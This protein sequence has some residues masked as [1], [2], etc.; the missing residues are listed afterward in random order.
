LFLGVLA[1]AGQALANPAANAPD[2]PATTES[3]DDGDGATRSVP[4]YAE[5]FYNYELASSTIARERL[6]G[7][8]DPTGGIPLRRD[9]EFTS[10]KHTITPRIQVG[11]FKD[12]F[13]YAALP[14][15]I[16]QA[17]E[18][19]LVEGVSRTSS[20]TVQ[21]GLLPPEG[22]DARD[23]GTMTPGDLMFRSPKR[24][25]IDQIH[26]GLGVAPMNQ[27]SDPTK[28]TWKLGA[29]VRLA[30]GEIMK[31]DPTQPNANKG[32]SQG[33]QELK[34]WTSFTRKLGWAAPWVEAFWMTPLTAKSGSLFDDPGFGAT[35]VNKAMQAGLSFGLEV[36]AVDNAV[37]N[38]RI[39]LDLGTRVVGHFEGREYTEMWE[40][41]AGAGDSRGMGPLI[42]DADPTRMGVQALSHPGVSNIENY[43]ETAGRFGLRAQIGPHVKFGLLA[44]V[45]WKT[46]HAISFADAGVDYPTCGTAG[47]PC[48]DDQ[49]DLVNPG[50]DEVN[51]LHA[52]P[53]DLVGHRYL[54]LDN[55][56]VLINVEAQVL[57]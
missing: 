49:N 33:V 43:L 2:A 19:S 40:V 26:L 20:T 56:D 9:L 45:V 39:S 57:F 34:L 46:D 30:I 8:A 53:I 41:F 55:F 38:T 42:L 36:F 54:S 22:F 24:R 35:N 50:T 44:D 28:P 12:T 1:A 23:P 4:F 29:E 5:V 18:L 10:F 37:E 52:A 11:V 3:P 47:G 21:D 7:G 15:V 14:I 31:F 32:V 17:R 16:A 13:I 51:P 48:E 6:S 25:G 27:D